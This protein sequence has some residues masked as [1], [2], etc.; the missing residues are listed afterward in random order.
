MNNLGLLVLGKRKLF[1][2]SSLNDEMS[3]NEIS[4]IRFLFESRH[5]KPFVLKYSLKRESLMAFL[6]ESE[7]VEVG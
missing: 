7:V 5:S 1:F 2:I 6:S 4:A 3:E